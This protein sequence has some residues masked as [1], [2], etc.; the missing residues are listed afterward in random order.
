MDITNAKTIFA[1]INAT[2]N[3]DTRFALAQT[4]ATAAKDII[5]KASSTNKGGKD[6]EFQSAL[7]ALEDPTHAR[8]WLLT[9]LKASVESGNTQAAKEIR[10]ILDIGNAS[11]EIEVHSVDYRSM[12]TDCPFGRAPDVPAV[13]PADGGDQ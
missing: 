12:C 7:A 10:D 9:N 2:R 13:D 6:G 1:A 5:T 11:N 8:A 3:G 4:I